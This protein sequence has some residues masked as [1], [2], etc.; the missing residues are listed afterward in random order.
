MKRATF[1]NAG[2]MPAE[3]V[4]FVRKSKAYTKREKMLN[5]QRNIFAKC[6][7]ARPNKRRC[8]Q[9]VE[10]SYS[11]SMIIACNVGNY[12]KVVCKSRIY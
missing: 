1:E 8:T 2:I 7:E 5:E 9:H 6:K 4:L 11:G 10:R 12:T 3:L